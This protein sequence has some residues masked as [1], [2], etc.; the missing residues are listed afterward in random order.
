CPDNATK[1][2]SA[3]VRNNPFFSRASIVTDREYLPFENRPVSV[4]KAVGETPVPDVD[5]TLSPL[6]VVSENFELTPRSLSAFREISVNRTSRRT[7]W[8]PPIESRLVT[9]SAGA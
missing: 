8:L 7:C 4:P 3:K 5:V 1:F 6:P 2:G 9:L